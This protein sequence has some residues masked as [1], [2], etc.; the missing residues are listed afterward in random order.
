MSFI[1]CALHAGNLDFITNANDKDMIQNAMVTINQLELWDWLKNF[2]EES[3]MYSN[4]PN[5]QVI[6]QKMAENGYDRH[7]GSSF[8]VTMRNMQYIAK[9]G[10]ENWKTLWTQQ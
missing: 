1:K 2:D 10:F 6:Y 8:G 5:I 3:F 9:H 4:S 7:S